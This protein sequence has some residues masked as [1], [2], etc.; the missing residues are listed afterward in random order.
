[1]GASGLLYGV[2]LDVHQVSVPQVLLLGGGST[3][4]VALH[5]AA[6]WYGAYRV[7]IPLLPRAGWRDPEVRAIIRLALPSSGHAALN[8]ATFFGLLVVAGAVPGGTVA[9]QIGLYFFNLPIALCARPLAAAQL[10]RLSRSINQGIQAAFDATY[11]NSVSLALFVAIPASLLF[12]CMPGTWARA[13]SF[14]EMHTGLGVALITAVIASLGAG[15]IGETIVIVATSASYARRDADLTPA[16]DRHPSGGGLRRHGD[17]VHADV[18]HRRAVDARRR[19]VGCQPDRRGLSASLPNPSA[20]PWALGGRRS[21][22][23]RSGR[24]G[25]SDSPRHARRRPPARRHP[26]PLWRHGDGDRRHRAERL[27]VSV[28]PM[29]ARVGAAQVPALGQPR[30]RAGEGRA[31]MLSGQKAGSGHDLTLAGAAAVALLAG[32]AVAHGGLLALAGVMAVTLA[33]IVAARPQVQA[34]L[35]LFANPLIVGIARGDLIPILR[36]DELLL[37]LLLAAW[38]ARIVLRLLAGRTVRP[39]FNSID[40]AMFF[41][42]VTSSV[43]PLLLRYNRGLAVTSDDFLYAIVLWKYLLLYWFYRGSVTTASQV[44]CCLWLSMSSAAVVAIVGILQVA[45]SVRHPP[46]AVEPT[47]MPRSTAFTGAR[48]RAGDLHPGIALQYRRRHDH[49]SGRRPCLPAHEAEQDEGC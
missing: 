37:I 46:V 13:V 19:L 3:A 32:V 12:L 45:N 23:R 29:A 28:H 24:R 27:A 41:L 21:G 15:V 49:K 36:P 9:F 11:R 4:A 17:R 7:G 8:C 6:Q 5:A 43:F 25:G 42:A 48:D 26:G 2:G 30:T 14:G 16:G 20:P 1:M 47:T 44:T 22:P 35:V 34:Y 40:L 10:P 38:A 33:A 31:V 39:E 18:R